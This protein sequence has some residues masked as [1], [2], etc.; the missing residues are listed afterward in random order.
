MKNEVKLEIYILLGERPFYLSTGFIRRNLK[1]P[2]DMMD[3]K[4]N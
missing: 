1:F 4:V 2:S 3:Y